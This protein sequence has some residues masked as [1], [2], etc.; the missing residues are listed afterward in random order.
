MFVDHGRPAA[1]IEIPEGAGAVERRAADILQTSI[2]KMTGVDL[3]ILT[4]KAPDGPGAAVLGFAGNDLPPAVTLALPA[5]HT[6]GFA[7]ATSAGNLYIMSGGG[8]GLVDGV[9][10]ILEKY[11]GCRRFSPTPEVFPRRDDLALGC[12][13]EVDNP[14]N[15]VRVAEGRFAPDPGFPDWRRP[16]TAADLVGGTG[17]PMTG[18]P[19][20][21]IKPVWYNGGRD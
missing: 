2:F 11:F 1:R 16:Y 20:G 13:F 9:V 4:V 7:I 5:L 6:G 15:E 12:L 3:P 14:E 18:S 21:Q 8:Q 19:F 10:H 17:E